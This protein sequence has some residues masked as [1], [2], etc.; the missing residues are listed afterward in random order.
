MKITRL[1]VLLLLVSLGAWPAS[2]SPLNPPVPP[3]Q[4]PGGPAL[5]LLGAGID[6]REPSLAARL[7]RDGEGEIIGWDFIENDRHPYAAAAAGADGG[8]ATALATLMMAGYSRGRLVPVRLAAGDAR[9]LARAI[10]FVAGTPARVVAITQPVAAVDLREVVRQAAERF[11]DRLF[12][13]EAVLPPASTKGQAPLPP[14]PPQA[15]DRDS[16]AASDQGALHRQANVLVVAAGTDADGHRAGAVLEAA[17]LI[18]VQRGS[19]L[20]GAPAGTPPR[21]AAEA[22][23]LAAAMAACQAHGRD[24]MSAADTKAAVLAAARPLEG[25]RAIRALDP[26]CLYGGRRVE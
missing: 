14:S 1:L 22:V 16:P 19:S 26:V 4:D 6:Y 9:M 24:D 17:D 5:A 15:G 25:A 18:V 21:D 20:F 8:T 2:S 11:P 12:V 13:V 7:A 23:V 10:G 3:G